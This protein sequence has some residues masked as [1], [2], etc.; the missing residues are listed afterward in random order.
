MI[1]GALLTDGGAGA[2]MLESRGGVDFQYSSQAIAAATNRLSQI[3]LLG[4]RLVAPR[5]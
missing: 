3:V 4:W 2:D 1:R 5:T